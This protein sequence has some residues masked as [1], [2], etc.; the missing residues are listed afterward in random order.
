[1][2]CVSAGVSQAAEDGS[3][4]LQF[5]FDNGTILPIDLPI[6]ECEAL[7]RGL[8]QELKTRT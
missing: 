4:R 7:V 5:M 6:V 8:A 2:K 1:M 3:V